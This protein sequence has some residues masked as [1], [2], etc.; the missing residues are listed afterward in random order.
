[1]NRKSK[2][3]LKNKLILY[4]C[5]IKP[6]WTYG[7]QLWGCAKSRVLRTI[8]NAPWYVSNRT[9]HNDLQVPYVTDE[10]RRLALLYKRRLQGHD[11]RLIE[12]IRNPPN[13]V[14]RLKR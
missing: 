6:I 5:I 12:E 7:V 11:N 10:I 9:L 4:K 14:R 3:S 8:T 13:V 2:L 1:M